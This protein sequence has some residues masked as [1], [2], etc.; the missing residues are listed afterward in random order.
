[1]SR[2]TVIIAEIGPNHN[3]SLA[4]AKKLIQSAKLSGADYVKFQTYKT[5]NIVLRNAKKAK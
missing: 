3:G 2:K 5:E 1:M 4:L